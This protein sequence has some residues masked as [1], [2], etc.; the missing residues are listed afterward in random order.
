MNYIFIIVG[1]ILL[2]K[3]ADIFVEG[4]SKIAKVFGIPSLVIGLTIVAFGT[5]APEAAVSIIASLTGQNTISVGNVVGSNICNLLL[6][7]GISSL[8]GKLTVKKEIIK[9][10][11]SYSIF[12]YIVL[13]IMTGIFFLTGNKLA[14]IN[15][16]S[17]VIL[18][19][20]IVFYLIILFIG[21]KNSIKKE[22]KEKFKFKYIIYIVLGLI[23]IIL[24]G[25]LV[26]DNATKI[27]KILG[28]SDNVIA[29][30]IVA[31][32]TSL[33]ELFTSAVAA[34]KGE[35]DIAIGNVIGSN[36]FNIF[37]ILG[38]SSI[39][40]DITLGMESFIDIIVMLLSGIITLIVIGK[41]REITSKKGIFM[42]FLYLIY[43]IYILNR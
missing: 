9:R 30:T 2:I 12:A 39:V 28:V 7:L 16:I 42:L 31:I 34:K 24:G 3:C 4:C 1:F 32:G 33:P 10:D 27:A 19:I 29:L 20:F 15:R 35:T 41:K 25:Q 17:G 21:T 8:F 40:G 6:V 43:I 23:G 38:L 26:V 14:Q 37:F 13:F 11:Y 18:L 22:E 5:S 36:I